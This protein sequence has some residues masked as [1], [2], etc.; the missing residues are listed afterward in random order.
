VVTS[1]EYRLYALGPEVLAGAVV[2]PFERAREV[3]GFFAEFVATAP[4]E[5]SVTASSLKAAPGSP[6]PAAPLRLGRH[7]AGGVLRGR[8]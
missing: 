4:D 2:H 7:R 1:F 5:L 6:S 3:L 8:P